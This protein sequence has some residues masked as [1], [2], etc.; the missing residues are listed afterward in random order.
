RRGA[1]IGGGLALALAAALAGAAPAAERAPDDGLRPSGPTAEAPAL[2]PVAPPRAARKIAKLTRARPICA[3]IETSAERHGL[4]PSYFARLIWRESRFDARALSPKGAQ[5]IAQFM[6]GTAKMVGLADP[7][8]PRQAIAASAAHLAEL[9]RAFGKWGL[10]AA[11]YNAGAGRVQRWLAGRS[12]LPY[13]TRAYVQA[14][15]GQ[16]AEAFRKRATEVGERPLAPRTAFIDACSAL[17]VMRTRAAG[18]GVR[19]PWG[20]QIAGNLNRNR[21][22]AQ[23]RRVRQRWSGILAQGPQQVIAKRGPR[24]T[25]PLWSVQVGTKS[26]AEAARIC[27]R[28]KAA[29]GA[30]VVRRN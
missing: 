1:R 13:E 6:P 15:T 26:R 21:A 4:P 22:V 10:A 24:G 3:L 20:V 30:C 19:L 29:G 25:R 14:V 23:A 5:G 9:R 17:P 18:G 11:G 27:R 8:D 12:G 2:A 28:L 7:W 16:P